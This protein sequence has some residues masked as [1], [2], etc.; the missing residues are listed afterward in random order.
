MLRFSP[1]FSNYMKRKLKRDY[2][3]RSCAVKERHPGINRLKVSFQGDN[4]SNYA[5]YVVSQ[6][7]I[8]STESNKYV[9]HMTIDMGTH[10][11]SIECPLPE[12]VAS[13]DIIIINLN[14]ECGNNTRISFPIEAVR[15]NFNF[16]VDVLYG[17]LLINPGQDTTPTDAAGFEFLMVF[18]VIVICWKRKIK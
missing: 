18:S 12:K 10:Q 3:I 16:S 11:G 9:N 17:P 15:N 2:L 1:F 5:I 4:T 6:D 8:S 13:A 7:Y 14:G